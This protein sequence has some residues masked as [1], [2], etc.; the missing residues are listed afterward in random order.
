MK[1]ENPDASE[2]RDFLCLFFGCFLLL[3]PI[4]PIT[5][6]KAKPDEAGNHPEK[7]C[8]LIGVIPGFCNT[9]QKNDK[10][11]AVKKGKPEGTIV[12]VFPEDFERFHRHASVCCG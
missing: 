11:K 6:G 10:S 5:G 2:H 7:K 1:N 12:F 8:G 4:P 3:Q 9:V